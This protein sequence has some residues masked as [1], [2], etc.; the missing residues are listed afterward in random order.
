[1]SL[2]YAK[3]S[4]SRSAARKKEQQESQKQGPT[5]EVRILDLIR[6]SG[7][8][9]LI[10]REV[11]RKTKLLHQSA[12]ARIRG[13]CEKGLVCDSGMRRKT[14]GGFEQI[15]WIPGSEDLQFIQGH[16]RKQRPSPKNL[17]IALAN[18]ERLIKYRPKR[19]VQSSQELSE[20]RTWI[21]AILR[22]ERSVRGR[23]KGRGT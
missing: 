11:E 1:M 14:P 18:I 23:E 6:K 3:R 21:R 22:Q 16:F 15:V 8:R 17:K 12:S 7:R 9:G 19:K 4:T 5:D 20:L 10:C 2:P 13:L